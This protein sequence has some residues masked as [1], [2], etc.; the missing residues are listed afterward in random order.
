MN[1]SQ[2]KRGVKVCPECDR[3]T[4]VRTYECECGYAFPM[5]KRRKGKRK[6]VVDDYKTLKHGDRVILVGSSG[7]YY[8]T[9][10]GERS[11]LSDRGV[12]RVISTDQNGVVATG[13]HGFAHLYM[14]KRCQG[15]VPSITKEPCKLLLI[16]D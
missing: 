5:K 12:Y 16:R 1:D 2:P 11:Y 7:P 8:V 4:G 13:K 6:T 9:K 14:G 10:E 3:Q 15:L